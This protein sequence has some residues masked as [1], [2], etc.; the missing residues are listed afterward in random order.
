MNEAQIKQLIEA[1]ESLKMAV[2]A[3]APTIN[4]VTTNGKFAEKF[5]NLEN[6]L[7]AECPQDSEPTGIPVPDALK[8]APVS[9]A[10][11]TN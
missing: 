9:Q 2:T 10:K 1:I 11:K 7:K 5:K 3:L 8:T 4:A 6:E